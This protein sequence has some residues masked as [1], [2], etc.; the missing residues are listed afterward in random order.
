MIGFVNP[1]KVFARMK[2]FL[3]FPSARNGSENKKLKNH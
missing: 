3:A 1:C 2:A